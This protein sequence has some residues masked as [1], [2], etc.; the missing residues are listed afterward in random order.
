MT[1]PRRPL[2]RKWRIFNRVVLL[3]LALSALLQ[4]GRCALRDSGGE[5]SME[6]LAESRV[7][8]LPERELSDS[9]SAPFLGNAVREI[10]L[11]HVYAQRDTGLAHMMDT[12]L[13]RY[14]PQDALYLA[15][16]PGTNEIVAWGER[17]DAP[18]R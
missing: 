15:V 9:A 2:P 17:K 13:R 11:E 6:N 3:V 16:D 1:F 12:F 8:T 4:C 18:C 10:N 5:G 7:E 14:R